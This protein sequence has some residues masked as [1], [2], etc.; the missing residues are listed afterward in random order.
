MGGTFKPTNVDAGGKPG[1]TDT[2]PFTPSGAVALST[3]DR[4]NPNGP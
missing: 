4:T 1:G 2:F 3:F